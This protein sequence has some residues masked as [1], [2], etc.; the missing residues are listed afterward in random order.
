MPRRIGMVSGMFFGLSF[1]LAGVGAAVLDIL[2][3]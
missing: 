2:A 1:G 3:D